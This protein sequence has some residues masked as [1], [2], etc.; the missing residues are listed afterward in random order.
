M[1]GVERGAK[2][3]W[4]PSSRG[5]QRLTVE[6]H[7]FPAL[8]L[9]VDAD[10]DV[11]LGTSPVELLAGAIASIFAWLVRDE[12]QAK[13]KQARE[14]T[15]YVTLRFTDDV[16]D[17]TPTTPE[18]AVGRVTPPA[19]SAVSVEIYGRIPALDQ[20]PFSDAAH[21]AMGRCVEMIGIR[22]ERVTM[23]VEAVLEGP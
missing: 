11:P 22:S 17:D 7:S 16:A 19:L 9:D 1:S 20:Q 18:K 15:C 23:T 10:A 14:L 6:S 21:A 8:K 2:L 5:I 3:R 12:L 4:S 13:D